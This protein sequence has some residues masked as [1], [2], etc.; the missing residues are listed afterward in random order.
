MQPFYWSD[1]RAYIQKELGIWIK[2]HIIRQ[3]LQNGFL[4]S[5]KIGSDRP[6]K[7]DGNRHKWMSALFWTNLL[8]TLSS[9]KQIINEDGY[10]LSRSIKQNYSWLAR[11]RSWKNK[12]YKVNGQYVASFHD[13]QRRFKFYCDFHL[14][15]KEQRLYSIF[16][17]SFS[18]HWKVR[19]TDN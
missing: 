3:L 18:I 9:A 8:R 12:Q 2:P 15:H 10:W 19:G 14:N 17:K 4:K 5:Y 11:G 6:S 7:L 13:F 16:R 1:L